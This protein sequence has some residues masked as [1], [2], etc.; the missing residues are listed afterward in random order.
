MNVAQLQQLVNE[1]YTEVFGNTPLTERLDDIDGEI[2][3]I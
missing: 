3:K 1:N 2:N